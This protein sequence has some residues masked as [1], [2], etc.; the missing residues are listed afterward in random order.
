MKKVLVTGAAGFVGF[1]LSKRLL[2]EGVSV[3]GVDNFSPYYD[4]KLKEDRVDQLTKHASFELSRIDV[5]NFEALEKVWMEFQP[6]IVIHLAAQA[7]VRHSITAPRSYLN[8]NINGTFNV[9]ELARRHPIE[10][11]L[12]ASSSS[13]YGANTKMPFD[14]RDRTASPLS[15][16]A[17]TKGAAEL[18]GH[19]YSHLYEIPMTFFRFFTVYGPWGRPDMAY[20]KF[21]KAIF[22]D[23]SIDVYNQGKSRRDFTYIDDL[24]EAVIRLKDQVPVSSGLGRERSSSSVAPYRVVNIGQAKPITLMEF[25]R[26]IEDATGRNAKKNFLSAQPGDVDATHASSEL[27]ADLTGFRVSTS[28]ID[29]LRA[30]VEWYRAYYLSADAQENG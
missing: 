3:L 10:H 15:L 11:L 20:F 2:T 14:E 12:I 19:S 9:L 4:V 25:I 7:G 27:L 1:H 23:Q 8:S 17:A 6:T 22:E 26:T 18:M 29:G 5:S 16:Y 30:F 24:V 13:V 21:V 28:L